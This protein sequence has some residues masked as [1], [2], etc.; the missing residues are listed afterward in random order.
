M[1]TKYS[2]TNDQLE[3]ILSIR[4]K[5]RKHIFNAQYDKAYKYLIK[6]YKNHPKS[7]YIPSMLAT[8]NTEKAF[9]MSDKY[10]D[11]YF[12]LAAKKLRVLLYA[13][14]GATLA[15]K[16]RNINEYY[17]FSQQH[18]KQYLFGVKDVRKGDIWG[19]YSQ[20]V[21]ASNYAYKLFTENKIGL[22]LKWANKAEL[23]WKEYFK[24]CTRD[25]YDPWCWYALALGLQGNSKGMELAL[26]KA[27]K[28]S[29]KNFKT[30]P[31]F[32]KIRKMVQV[33]K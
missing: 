3:P 25:Y 11:K 7:Y 2:H 9:Y 27:S 18:K 1:K 33:F 14:N 32:K 21:G 29:K 16:A 28:L 23:I 6:E 26:K 31:F 10:K 17:W 5:V 12:A 13:V 8:L 24:K 30:H 19:L 15:L 20:G 22:G 4:Q